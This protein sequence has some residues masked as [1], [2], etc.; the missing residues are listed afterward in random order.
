MR[1]LLRALL[2]HRH[3]LWSLIQL[4]LRNR[5]GASFMGLFWSVINP[6]LQI[7]MY[8]FVFGYILSVNAGGNP[9]TTNYGIF[10]FA[11]MLPWIAFSE[12]IQ[13]TSTV[14]LE[15]KSLVKQVRFPTVLLPLQIL[16]S[17]F[18]H[19]MIALII[20]IIILFIVGQP[21]TWLA[22]GL[23]ALFPLQL[24]FSLGLGLI[25]SAFHVFYKD[26]GQLVSAFLILWFFATPIVYPI[27]II[28]D[29]VQKF[30]YINPLTP[31]ISAYRSALLHDEVPEIWS[32]VYLAVLSLVLFFVGMKLFLRLSRDFADLL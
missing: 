20:F 18:L 2:A 1:D 9:G 12:T 27:S 30:Y 4:D 32:F 13:K 31:L 21:P 25:T 3:L 19:E 29:W 23:I 14:I 7:L 15:N 11:G 10:L 22:L 24:I 16:F 6:L 5:Y 26:V 17:S 8:T 28:P